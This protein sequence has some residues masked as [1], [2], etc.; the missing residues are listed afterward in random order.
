MHISSINVPKTF[1]KIN[2]NVQIQETSLRPTN[3]VIGQN[4]SNVDTLFA[5][6]EDGKYYT[7]SHNN[8][9]NNGISFY[10]QMMWVRR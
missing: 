7:G 1:T 5:V 2:D 4:Y 6:H 8:Q 3:P 10:T 9:A